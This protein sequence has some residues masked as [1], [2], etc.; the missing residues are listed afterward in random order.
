ML[1]NL[2]FLSPFLPPSS[3][4]SSRC[5]FTFVDCRGG[6]E[7]C[8]SMRLLEGK[9]KERKRNVQWRNT[10]AG[11]INYLPHRRPPDLTLSLTYVTSMG[12]MH[13]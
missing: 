5:R 8:C 13:V 1:Y 4:S 11:E 9:S 10:R 2:P 12:Q 7:H 3:S 6:E